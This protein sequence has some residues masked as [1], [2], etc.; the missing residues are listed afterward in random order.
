MYTQHALNTQHKLVPNVWRISRREKE[1]AAGY[2]E[3]SVLCVVIVCSSTEKNRLFKL[4][5]SYNIFHE[6]IYTNIRTLL[7]HSFT[8]I[9]N[10]QIN[11]I[12]LCCMKATII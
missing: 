11:I 12:V 3:Q 9:C 5:F 1:V 4:L 10:S 2:K 7:A 6:T 8:H